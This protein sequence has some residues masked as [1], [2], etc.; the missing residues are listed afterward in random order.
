ME[1]L[2]QIILQ[3]ESYL[4]DGASFMIDAENIYIN[5]QTQEI[6]LTYLPIKVEQDIK[7]SGKS[8]LN[9][10]DRLRW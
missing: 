3:A 6:S 1:K 10:M 4:L 2:V 9:T 7:R 8:F 5:P